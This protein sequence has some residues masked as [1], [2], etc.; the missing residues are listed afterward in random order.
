MR[1]SKATAHTGC[2][3][4]PPRPSQK[5]AHTNHQAKDPKRIAD[6]LVAAQERARLKQRAPGSAPL[7]DPDDPKSEFVQVGRSRWD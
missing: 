7:F 3:R 6:I 4:G 5:F 2:H 1:D